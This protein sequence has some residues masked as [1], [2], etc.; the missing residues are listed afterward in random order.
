MCVY[1]F[2]LFIQI[3]AYIYSLCSLLIAW[4]LCVSEFVYVGEWLLQL[5]KLLSAVWMEL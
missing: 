4:S 1:V 3:H 5:A 2:A